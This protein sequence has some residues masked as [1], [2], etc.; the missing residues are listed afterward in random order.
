MNNASPY[1]N[2]RR[3]WDERYGDALARAKSWKTLAISAVAVAGIAV[4]GIAYIGAQSKIQPFV[5]A[6][7]QMGSP[8]L[9][10]R[11]SAASTPQLNDRVAI[12][13]IANW[14][15]N[16][17]TM[18][19]DTDA[20][21]VLISKVYSMSGSDTGKYLNTYFQEHSPFSTDGSVVRITI[22][23][24]M[25]VGGST[26]QVNWTESRS[27]PG[28]TVVTEKWQATLT[29]AFDPKLGEKPEVALHN[30]LGIYVKS[31]SWARSVG[32]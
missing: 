20:Q 15:W 14:I 22:N 28:R 1:L 26:Y 21:Q 25:P 4:A 7:D 8:V 32:G 6:I 18:L 5:V 31:M 12:A 11:P 27:Q 13:Q 16:A 2:A 10:A 17:R 3:E 29:V 30:P 24:V 9:V 23:S 19:V